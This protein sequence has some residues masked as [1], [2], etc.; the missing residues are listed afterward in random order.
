MWQLTSESGRRTECVIEASG[1]GEHRLLI[2][3]AGA[4]AAT[5][6]YASELLART[7]AWELNNALL[8]R[9]WSAGD[10]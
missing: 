1:V 3:H 5:E 10:S 4:I 8:T 6:V 2:L 7:R 9:G